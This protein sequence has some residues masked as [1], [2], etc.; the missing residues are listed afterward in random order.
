[1]NRESINH[2]AE[3]IF[4]DVAYAA[5]PERIGSAAF[6]NT[7]IDMKCSVGV[8]SN[9]RAYWSKP[10]NNPQRPSWR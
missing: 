5:S 2:F 7:L 10:T 3:L 6:G 4:R 8:L 9:S 1:M